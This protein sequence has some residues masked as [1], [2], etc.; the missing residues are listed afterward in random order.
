MTSDKLIRLSGLMCIFT[1]VLLFLWWGLMGM[2]M[3]AGAEN[4]SMLEM[5]KSDRWLPVNTIGC[6]AV[7]LLP[8]ALIGL[9]VRQ[10][11]AVKIV[12]L[13]GFLLAFSGSL[14]YVWLQVEESILWPI[15]AVHAP[16]LI[17]M[18]GPMFMNPAFSFT[19]MLMGLLFI[20]GLLI[21]GAATIHAG[22]L[23][24]WGAVL[25]TIGGP[26]FGIGGTLFVVRT[27]GVILFMAGLVWLGLALWRETATN[28]NH[29][30]KE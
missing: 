11:A 28:M 19:Y 15:L 13:V 18:S 30:R 24:R 1:G 7:V 27:I 2:I 17:D 21:L 26:L 10:I 8:L 29:N 20:P 6:I 22:I 23:P 9:Y 5:V 16:A 3:P 25:F 4:F 14:L 12:G